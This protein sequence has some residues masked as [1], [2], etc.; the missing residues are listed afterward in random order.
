MSYPV[1]IIVGMTV[2]Y[3][4]YQYRIY[5]TPGQRQMLAR[6]FGCCR[7]VWNDALRIFQDAY[8]AGEE[9]PVFGA[10]TTAV[11]VS[12][13]RTVE[14]A[15]LGEVSCVPLQQSMRQLYSA[16]GS[17]F[18]SMSGKRKGPKVCPPRFKRRSG[19]QSAEFTRRGFVLRGNGRLYLAKI[20]EVKVAW[21]RELPSE[22]SS[23]TVIKEATGKYF[24]SF[25]V[26]VEGEPL[27][28]L[29]EGSVVG[30]DLGLSVFAVTSG[31]KRIESPKF[32]R[33]AE[34][35][36]KKY[37][38]A[39]S[40]KEKGSN[41]RRKA[42]LKLAKVHARVAAQRRDF[43]EQETTRLVR[44]NQTIAV[45]TL[46]V[47]GMAAKGMHLGKS[48][49]DQALGMF[50]RVLAA[51]A[52][53]AGRTVIA[54]DRF[55]ASTQICSECEAKT[56]PKGKE[57][58]HIREWECTACGAVHDR[59]VNAAINILREG[60][61]LIAEVEQLAA[62]HQKA[63]NTLPGA[64]SLNACGGDT[65]DQ[66]TTGSPRDPTSG[67]TEPGTRAEPDDRKTNR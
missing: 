51:K 19:R 29:G 7:T 38:R 22:P 31:G 58:L 6:T 56:G 8:K 61:R 13:K 40:R 20:G 25:V 59:D 44:E 26:A 50:L 4:R 35:K 15:W 43:I 27:P 12:A 53:R 5:P 62:G 32:L 23:V 36:I 24:V 30:I 42:R 16:F 18:N 47:K 55:Y 49:H 52:A 2:D 45:E 37:Q 46:N 63:R 66:R 54:V 60:L 33:R 39:V 67:G 21:S 9:R 48:V 65:Q 41:N 17:F 1:F 64:E 3:I 14:R 28:D 11:T 57:E 10:V 34:R